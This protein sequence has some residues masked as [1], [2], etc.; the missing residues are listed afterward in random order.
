MIIPYNAS[1]RAKKNY[2][3]DNLII[4]HYDEDLKCNWYKL[5]GNNKNFINDKDANL[6][7]KCLTDVVNNDFQKI[8]TH[9]MKF[10]IRINY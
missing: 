5:N 9:N 4:D 8:G 1:H 2:L 7:I 6:L 3:T 10:T